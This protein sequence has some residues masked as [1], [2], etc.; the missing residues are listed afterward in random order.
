LR[1]LREQFPDV[2]VA[3]F[4]ATATR[5]VQEDIVEQLGLR[6]PRLFQGSFNRANLFY[7]VLP[8]Q[9][10]YTRLV[11]YL[12]SRPEDSGIIYCLSRA[13]TE[14]LAARLRGDGF[15]AIAYHAGLEAEER[16]KRQEA[17]IRD[18]V[19]IVVAT[20]AFGMGID[21]PDVRYVIHYDLPKNLEGYYQESGRAGR[22]GEPSE[23]VLFYSYADAA[24]H[25]HFIAERPPHEQ[26]IAKAQLRSMLDWAQSPTCRRRAL[27]AYFD[28]ELVDPPE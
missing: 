22:D 25:E 6:Q 9:Q 1:S 5:R 12:R 15:S 7:Q 26:A 10:A 19:R 21:K 13:G 27:L 23:C 4:T 16:R 3:A 11:S 8:K 28:E 24:K 2:P 18:D 20:I 17:F 14:A